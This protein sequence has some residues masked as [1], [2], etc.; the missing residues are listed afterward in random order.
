M[1]ILVQETTVNLQNY[2]ALAFTSDAK[3][4]SF[5][6]HLQETLHV[7]KF[8]GKT[9]QVVAAPS[10]GFADASSVLIAGSA[11][12]N[13]ETLRIAARAAGT[14]ARKNGC[15]HVAILAS[16]F[17]DEQA[18]AVLTGFAAGN[19]RFDKYKA[20]Q[21][22]TS[23]VHSL[24]IVG[25]IEQR[26]AHK[27]TA[28]INGRNFCRDLV[29]GPPAEIYPETLAQAARSLT[30]DNIDVLVWEEDKLKEENMNGIIAVGQGSSNPSRFIHLTY[31]PSTP[32][33]S[34]FKM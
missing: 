4:Q 19:Y 8:E 7:H 14:K 9:G 24:I 18:I 31:K 27:A 11:N 1:N 29:N 23:G 28:L 33:Q 13:K 17:N 26:V 34:R 32:S 2:T 3:H 22:R 10:F 6:A 15:S 16:D 20:Q 30:N 5:P 25:N 12:M 21:K